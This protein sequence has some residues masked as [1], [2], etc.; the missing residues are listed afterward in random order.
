M[1]KIKY[2]QNNVKYSFEHVN[3]FNVID[4]GLTIFFSLLFLNN[5]GLLSKVGKFFVFK[6]CQTVA[7]ATPVGFLLLGLFQ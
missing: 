3:V 2:S 5:P 6:Y 4:V 7:R 1:G